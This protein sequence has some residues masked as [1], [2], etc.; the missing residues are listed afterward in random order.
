MYID[1]KYNCQI[2]TIKDL[3]WG[4]IN[5]QELERINKLEWIDEFEEF[6][7]MCGHYF[8]SIAKFGIIEQNDIYNVVDF[9]QL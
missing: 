1:L 7:L 5:K 6:N 9:S 2:K 4:G 3:Y 8:I